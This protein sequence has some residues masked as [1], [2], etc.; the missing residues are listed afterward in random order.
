V[1]FAG[2]SGRHGE[3][4]VEKKE[5]TDLDTEGKGREKPWMMAMVG[6]LRL[7]DSSR[8]SSRPHDGSAPRKS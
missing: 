7:L 1:L 2:M 8:P 6:P 5:H 3:Q 4:K